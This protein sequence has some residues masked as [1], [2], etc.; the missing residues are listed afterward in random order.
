MPKRIL[1]LDN[2][3]AYITVYVKYLRGQAEPY[4]VEMAR[5]L[6]EA[7]AKLKERKP[8]LLIL[9]VMVSTMTEEEARKYP[10]EETDNGLKTGLVFYTRHREELAEAGTKVLA[11]TARIDETIR[12]SFIKVGLPPECFTKKAEVS[13]VTEFMEKV[14]EVLGQN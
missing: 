10:P 12:Q 6:T 1:W 4:D 3:P 5:T 8:H 9:D 11:L 13:E 14:E 7:E 2:D